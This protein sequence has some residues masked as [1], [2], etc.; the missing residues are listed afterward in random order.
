MTRETI[1]IQKELFD[2]QRSKVDKYADLVVG[3]RGFVPLLRYELVTMLSANR[4]GAFGLWLRSKLYPRLLGRCGRNVTFGQGV[5]LRHPHKIVIGDDVVIDDHVVLDAKGQ[6]NRGIAIGRGVFVG[7]NTILSCKNGD[8]TLED[9]VNIGFN[10]EIFSA[11]TVTVGARTLLA[12]YT[13]LVGGDHDFAQ[14]DVAILDQGRSSKGIAIGEGAWLG[15]GVKVLD[16]CHVGARAIVG[17]GAVVT[18]SLPE[19]VIAVGVPA[20]V[21]RGR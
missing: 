7:R 15:A 16:G 18:S 9:G 10:C 19:A 5:V 21:V 13:Y 14:A 11:S 17:T 3:R 12:A 1:E 4:A 2:P 8:I 6:S 20:K